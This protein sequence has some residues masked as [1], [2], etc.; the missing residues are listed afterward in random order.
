MLGPTFMGMVM[1]WDFVVGGPMMPVAKA[2]AARRRRCLVMKVLNV[3]VS[4]KG[5]R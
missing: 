4:S 1:R 2:L 3:V 5:V